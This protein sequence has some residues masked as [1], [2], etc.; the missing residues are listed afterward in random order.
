MSHLNRR[1]KCTDGREQVRLGPLLRSILVVPP[2]RLTCILTL[3]Q[4][5]T[6]AD[7]DGR[8]V[9]KVLPRAQLANILDYDANTNDQCGGATTRIVEIRRRISR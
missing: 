5:A 2:T 1:C 8:S 7:Y 4:D 6:L 3:A 9:T